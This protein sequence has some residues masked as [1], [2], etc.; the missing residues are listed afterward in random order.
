LKKNQTGTKNAED[1]AA[2]NYSIEDKRYE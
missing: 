2:Q 1:L